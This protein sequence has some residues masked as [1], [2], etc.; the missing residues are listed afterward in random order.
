MI[1]TDAKG[2]AERKYRET[3]S[4]FT[5]HLSEGLVKLIKNQLAQAYLDGC[6]AILS[7]LS[8]D[9]LETTEQRIERGNQ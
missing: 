6:M 9:P 3:L 4:E 5:P 8:P 1:Y 7:K 2:Y